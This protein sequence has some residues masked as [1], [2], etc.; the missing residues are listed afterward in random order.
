VRSGAAQQRDRRRARFQQ[1]AENGLGFARD[2]AGHGPEN[3]RR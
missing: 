3:K 1:L 2:K